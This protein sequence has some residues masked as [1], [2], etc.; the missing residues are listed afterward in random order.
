MKRTN[1]N[2]IDCSKTK[3]TLKETEQNETTTSGQSDISTLKDSQ[4]L[5]AE[6]CDK[7]DHEN[8]YHWEAREVIYP[9]NNGQY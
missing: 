6:N 5:K 9:K 3:T 4:L 7:M 2:Q 8:F 1:H